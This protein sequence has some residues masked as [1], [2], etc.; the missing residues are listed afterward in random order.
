[1]DLHDVVHA[2]DLSKEVRAIARRLLDSR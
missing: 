1:V 2:R